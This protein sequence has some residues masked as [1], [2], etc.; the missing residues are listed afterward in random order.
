MRPAIVVVAYNRP[1]SLNR[2]L[3]SLQRASYEGTDIPLVISIDFGDNREVQRA[4]DAFV[5][6][7]GEK[8]V[9]CHTENL[10]L[11]R[12]VLS[13]GDLTQQYGS[14]I[15]LED[16]L[17]VSGGFYGYACSAL[18]FT[19]GDD[20][21]GGVSLYNH[22][23]NVHMRE[24]FEARN[25]GYDNWYFQFASS[26]GQAF[27]AKQWKGFRN[28]LIEHD[29]SDIAD[30]TVPANVSGWGDKS[31]L[32]YCI[33]Y[34]IETNRY[35]L[36][37]QVSHTTNFFDEG[38]HSRRAQ[39]D[40]QVPLSDGRREY[41]FSSL[42]QSQ[43]V[44]DAFFENVRLPKVLG[45][46][47]EEVEIDLYGGKPL[48]KR[49]CLTMRPLPCQVIRSF[50]CRLRPPDENIICKIPGDD[51]FLYDTSVPAKAPA[52]KTGGRIL[53]FYRGFKVKYIRE[54]LKTR[55]KERRG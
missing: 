3:E 21:I 8:R 5:W 41:S 18:E 50:G 33:R 42:E 27:T 55:W 14:I 38:T 34:L 12:H 30:V 54:I 28:W 20:R 46:E 10:G 13:C 44:Y 7:H 47:N 53:Y 49:Y 39:T 36:Y 40:F 43:A 1:H 15:M 31:W 52:V 4:A 19:K 37:P 16:D 29:G 6:E 32:K 25:D 11:K 23:F 26:W 51:F 22:R 35:F 48:T 2:I 45:M 9:I 17:F 24:C